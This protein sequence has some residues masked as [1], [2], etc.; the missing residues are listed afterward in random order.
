MGLSKEILRNKNEQFIWSRKISNGGRLALSNFVINLI[1]PSGFTIKSI[2]IPFGDIKGNRIYVKQIPANFDF[3]ISV[4]VVTDIEVNGFYTLEIQL[5]Q[6]GGESSSKKDV[7]AVDILNG[8]KI[9]N[10]DD[11]ILEVNRK[12]VI[13]EASFYEDCDTLLKEIQKQQD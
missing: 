6:N 11:D 2:N 8:E 1:L 12:F 13:Q 5:S 3:D 7:I 4:E 10:I 9:S